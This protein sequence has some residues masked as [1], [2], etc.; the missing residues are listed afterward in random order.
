MFWIYFMRT[1]LTIEGLTGAT[2]NT[3]L[4]LSMSFKKS[5]PADPAYRVPLYVFGFFGFVV[6]SFIAY[7]NFTHIFIDDTFV[8]FLIGVFEPLIP[9]EWRPMGY[10]V[11]LACVSYM[12]VLIPSTTM[13]QLTALSRQTY[14]VSTRSMFES[15]E[16]MT[17]LQQALEF[18]KTSEYCI[19][20][21]ECVVHI[22]SVQISVPPFRSSP[23]LTDIMDA[24]MIEL[25]ELEPNFT[26][27]TFSLSMKYVD[28]NYGRTLIHFL[29]FWAIIPYF[30]CYTALILMLVQIRKRLI[31]TGMALSDRTIRLQRQFFVMQLLQSFL[32]LGVLGIPLCMFVYGIF[33]EG[34]LGL[35][36]LPIAIA[37]WFCPIVLATVQL[38][39]I[40]QSTAKTPAP[41]KIAV[42]QM[43]GFT[44][45]G[46]DT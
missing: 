34:D 21:S 24:K 11:A 35:I 2:L 9:E 8:V 42:S 10:L 38:R 33:I 41:S 15:L 46:P 14:S 16:L 28:I 26:V 37:L 32:P 3:V 4:V 12:W 18:S 36:S 7:M 31:A 19:H 27:V 43:T 23:E 17:S 13:L 25:F 45:P 22:N 6:S 1:I 39:Y 20:H 44:L 5:G 30:S 29:L 40:H